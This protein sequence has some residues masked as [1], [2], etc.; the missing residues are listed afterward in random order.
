MR[1]ILEPGRPSHRRSGSL[2]QITRIVF[3]IPEMVNDTFKEDFQVHWEDRTSALLSIGILP[4]LGLAAILVMKC[5]SGRDLRISSI[6]AETRH[7]ALDPWECVKWMRCCLQ[8][9]EY[10][11]R[12]EYIKKNMDGKQEEHHTS[13]NGI[14]PSQKSKPSGGGGG[15]GKDEVITAALATS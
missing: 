15:G 6:V 13:G 10:L 12:A 4:H 8:F 5:E 11:E 14:G 7:I 1:K 9:K 2:Y 3:A